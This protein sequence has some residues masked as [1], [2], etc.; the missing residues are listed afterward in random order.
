MGDVQRILGG[1]PKAA[2]Y[3]IRPPRAGD[4]GWTVHRHGFLYSQEYGWDET[5]EALV[6][7][8]ISQYVAQD[9]SGKCAW[10]AEVGGEPVGF[11]ACTRK[12]DQT[13]QLRLFLVEPSARGMGIGSR[14]VDECLRF[15]RIAGY[16]RIMLWT[17]SVLADARRIYQRAG[18]TLDVERPDRAF[19]HDL[20]EQIWSRDL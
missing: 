7:E 9:D 20:V 13:A 19:G 2:P 16:A 15:A 10:I 4:L 17:Y 8:I 18:F 3:L 14:L 11:I 6:A 1:A 5:F 12:D